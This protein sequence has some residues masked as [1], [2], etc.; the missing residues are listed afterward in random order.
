MVVGFGN[1]VRPV[2]KYFNSKWERLRRIFVSKTRCKISVNILRDAAP[3]SLKRPGGFFF[4][5]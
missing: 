5:Y 4:G 1:I 2:P 3:Q